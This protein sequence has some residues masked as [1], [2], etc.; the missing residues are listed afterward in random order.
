MPGDGAISRGQGTGTLFWTDF[1]GAEVSRQTL[2]AITDK[3]RDRA[4][5]APA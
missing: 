1:Q 2:S 3:V 5:P 4:V